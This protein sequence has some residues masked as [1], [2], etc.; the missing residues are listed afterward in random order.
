MY[1]SHSEKGMKRAYAERDWTRLE[2]ALVEMERV[3]GLKE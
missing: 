3:V 2:R 1:L